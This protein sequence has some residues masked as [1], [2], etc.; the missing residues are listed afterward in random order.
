MGLLSN[1]SEYFASNTYVQATENSISTNELE[2]SIDNLNGRYQIGH[3]L[4]GKHAES[5]CGYACKYA[6]KYVC[7]YVATMQ[8]CVH[9][10]S[11]MRICMQICIQICMQKPTQVD[12]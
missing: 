2:N 1:I 10:D 12:R 4:V 7:K 6:Y 11:S 9:G 5:H 8:V 3:T